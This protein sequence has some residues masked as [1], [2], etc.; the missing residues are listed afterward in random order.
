[1]GSKVG[2]VSLLAALSVKWNLLKNDFTKMAYQSYY[3]LNKLKNL[4]RPV[5]SVLYLCYN[6]WRKIGTQE[7][8][9]LSNLLIRRLKCLAKKRGF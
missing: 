4:T 9:K 8:R 3:Y 7:T 5:F 6:E 1:M 2:L